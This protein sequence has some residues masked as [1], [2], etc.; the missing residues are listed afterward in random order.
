MLPSP[1]RFYRSPPS[2][3]SKKERRKQ[4]RKTRAADENVRFYD[5][6][7]QAL[8]IRPIARVYG[9]TDLYKDIRNPE[10]VFAVEEK[11]SVLESGAAQVIAGLHDALHKGTLSIKR[12]A[13]DTLRKFMFL[14]HYRNQALSGT[15][16]QH[17]HPDNLWS[18]DWISN[19]R[20]TRELEGSADMWLHVL[21]YYLDTP[22]Y[23]II[24]H[25]EK[26]L[27]QLAAGGAPPGLQDRLD[28]NNEHYEAIAYYSQAD[29]YFLCMWEAA[30]GEEFLLSSHSF[31]LWEGMI[32][33]P[34]NHIHRL[35]V[36]SPRLVLVLKRT[37]LRPEHTDRPPEDQLQ[38]SLLDI[39]T[40]TPAPNYPREFASTQDFDAHRASAAA[41]EDIFDFTITKLT[42]L[43]TYAVN[44]IV[45]SN[46]RDTGSL[47]FSSTEC[48]IRT[49]ISY[50]AD[51]NRRHTNW[52]KLVP[53]LH[54]LRPPPADPPTA[55]SS[56]VHA[57]PG[58]LHPPTPD[59]PA[60]QGDGTL[61]DL[62]IHL[63]LA[64]FLAGADF[65]SRYDRAHPVFRF[66]A[67]GDKL[68][69]PHA[70]S[71]R[72]LTSS[73]IR[74]FTTLLNLPSP[75]A[76]K[77]A[78]RVALR[79]SLSPEQSGLFF[80]LAD[81]LGFKY[82]GAGAISPQAL[83]GDVAIIGLFDWLAKYQTAFLESL[84][85]KHGINFLLVSASD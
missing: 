49:G 71:C 27:E 29:M 5:I 79:D 80:S 35:F 47:T 11:L 41:S 59:P 16:F 24:S 6:P 83:M 55:A 56:E 14:M 25:A 12:K 21:K 69:H 36:V 23:T 1:A 77:P 51:P 63:L 40:H 74:R 13:V 9:V 53:L 30:D 60:T 20:K 18:R 58:P 37:V 38:S 65:R 45:L 46:V 82:S 67:S 4:F 52:L 81:K 42:P 73:V 44:C 50:C 39:P 28:P 66:V 22:H 10:N 76:S 70:V 54:Q 72:E 48:M 8:D 32:G 84:L 57:D 78:R 75:P 33:G 3:R 19:Y 43:Q 2:S 34:S 68:T 64:R 17:D 31:G 85:P 61:A 62:T 15:Y 26:S 7:A